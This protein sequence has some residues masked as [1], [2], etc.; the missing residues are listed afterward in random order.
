[1]IRKPASPTGPSID[2]GATPSVQRRLATGLPPEVLPAWQG[3]LERLRADPRFVAPDR[4]TI[5]SRAF[6]DV[7]NH[8]HA[9]LPLAWR[10]CWT[11]RNSQGGAKETVTVLFL[12]THKQY[13]ELYGFATS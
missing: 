11:I 7:P 13:D 1:M 12:G 3:L 10:A 2:L 4:R 8:R 6:A 9:D 5:W